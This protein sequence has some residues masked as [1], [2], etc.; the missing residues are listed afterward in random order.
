MWWR[1]RALR[2]ITFLVLTGC[3]AATT[4]DPTAV[5]HPAVGVD[6]R[7]LSPVHVFVVVDGEAEDLGVVKAGSQ[8][9]L[10]LPRRVVGAVVQFAVGAVDGSARN[11]LQPIFR[12]RA[13]MEFLLHLLPEQ[14]P[15]AAHT[16]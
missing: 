11:F 4:G 7:S 2:G 12:F 8:V 3:A 6:N 14:V 5:W 9:S 15:P 1:W 13:G 10:A 16:M